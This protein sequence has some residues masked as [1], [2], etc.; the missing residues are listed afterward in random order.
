MVYLLEMFK[1][2]GKK[3]EIEKENYGVFDGSV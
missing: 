2:P 3:F 1:G